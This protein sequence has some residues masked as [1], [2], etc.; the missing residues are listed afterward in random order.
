MRQSWRARPYLGTAVPGTDTTRTNR[1]SGYSCPGTAVLN[2]TGWY[3]YFLIIIKSTLQLFN[4][5]VVQL[6]NH[7]DFEASKFSRYLSSH[8]GTG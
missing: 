7:P 2:L 8:F 1:S 6:I 5:I 3:M 4:L